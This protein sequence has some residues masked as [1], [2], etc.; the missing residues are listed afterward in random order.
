MAL[1]Y[2]LCD[3]ANL[4]YMFPSQRQILG[5]FLAIHLALITCYISKELLKFHDDLSCIP[6]IMV[7]QIWLKMSFFWFLEVILTLNFFPDNKI[8]IHNFISILRHIRIDYQHIKSFSSV[9]SFSFWLSI[10]SILVVFGQ[11]C[12]YLRAI[13]SIIRKDNRFLDGCF[14][15]LKRLSISGMPFNFDSNVEFW[16]KNLTFLKKCSHSLWR[17]QNVSTRNFVSNL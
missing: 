7:A 17:H 6:R 13:I 16:P 9:G 12:I 14:G 1:N 10:S 5:Y 11:C 8:Y 2:A 3:M 15:K 4:W